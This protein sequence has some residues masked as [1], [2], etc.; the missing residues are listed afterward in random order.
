MSASAVPAPVF[1]AFL[2]A[3]PLALALF[4]CPVASLAGHLDRTA[5]SKGL[6]QAVLPLAA[7]A[8]A[9]VVAPA[10]EP[11]MLETGTLPLAPVAAA[12]AAVA[13]L[14][15][16]HSDCSHPHLPFPTASV[17]AAVVAPRPETRMTFWA[18]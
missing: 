6:E 8:F 10:M 1:L 2:A 13:A 5:S 14:S 11:V 15:P 16:I 12:A 3:S 7:A 18:G 9:A 17:A 4:P